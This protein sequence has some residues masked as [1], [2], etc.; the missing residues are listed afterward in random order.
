[1]KDR[2]EMELVGH[3]GNIFGILGRAS[4]LLK[5]NG[6]AAESKEMFDR[7]TSCHSYDEAL[8][9]ISEYVQTELSGDDHGILEAEDVEIDSEMIPAEDGVTAYVAPPNANEKKEIEQKRIDQ[10]R[11]RDDKNEIQIVNVYDYDEGA[12]SDPGNQLIRALSLLS[13]ISKCLPNFEHLMKKSDKAEFVKMIYELPNRIF[14][15]FACEVDRQIPELVEFLQEETGNEFGN[16]ENALNNIV[17]LLQRDSIGLLLEIYNIATLF[18]TKI[19]T[20][21]L[22]E[23]HDYMSQLTYRI[24]H[25]LIRMRQNRFSDFTLES[26]SIAK[27]SKAPIVEILVKNVARHYYFCGNLDYKQQQSLLDSHFGK[28]EQAKAKWI[29]Q[30]NKKA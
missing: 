28:Q 10:E 30:T 22:L 12:I 19:N 2:P 8:N 20:V 15:Q 26:D 23:K 17:T 27:D 7:T 4:R 11:Q 21:R 9:I 3:D 16:D 14:Y 29:A 18:S 6:L 13:V 24:Q 5:Q 25:L 1:M